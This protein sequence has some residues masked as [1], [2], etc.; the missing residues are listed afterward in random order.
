[1]RGNPIEMNH[2]FNGIAFFVAA[3]VGLALLTPV[4]N[5]VEV[6][7]SVDRNP[8]Y[9]DESVNLVLSAEGDEM[10]GASPDL[11]PLRKDFEILRQSTQTNINIVNN[12]PHVVQSWQIEI[13]PK[14]LGILEIPALTIAGE[15]TEPIELDVQEFKGNVATA[16]AEIFLE[17]VVSTNNP[18]VQAQVNFITRLYYSIPIVNGTLSEPE[19]SFATVTGP[20]Q[21]KRYNAKRAG[22]DY[23]VVERRYAMFPEQSGLFSI[24]P[25][26][27]SAV[28][29]RVDP[30]TNQIRHLSERYSSIPVELDVR[31]IPRSY[32]GTTWLPAQEL[33]LKDS[34]QGRQ[35][36][37][38]VGKPES[39]AITIDA[40]GLRAVQLP[41]VNYE[42]NSTARVYGSNNA[43]LK[44][45]PTYD[46]SVARRTDEFAIIPQSDTRV[47]V[48]RF[49]LVWWDVNEDREKIAVL[50][51]I[52]VNLDQSA[53][54]SPG[55]DSGD[56]NS[57]ADMN[58][59][60]LAL[61]GVNPDAQW[62]L[63]SLALLVTWVLTLLTWFFSRRL[64]S[65][66]N[67]Q[68]DIE[69]H[70][71]R[72]QNIETERQA[73]RSVKRACSQ[74]DALALSNALLNWAVIHWPSRP[75]RNLIELGQKLDSE[76][77]T[78]SLE[79]VDRAVYSNENVSLQGRV[80]WR[81]LVTAL[82]SIQRQQGQP[83]RFKWFK[84][85]TKRLEDLWP[86]KDPLGP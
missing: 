85:H 70:V 68:G 59:S 81:N 1:M 38:E 13:Q 79:K 50:P 39:R 63:I 74:N 29:E 15:H 49:E 12:T 46:W 44:T 52:S 37:F 11:E 41:M 8:V 67:M 84:P 33:T 23:R 42:E 83:K 36:D 78:G 19:V 26:Q 24:P 57:P 14:R 53:V 21:D 7:A 73:L 56:E 10:S 20:A 9:L 48:P 75:P 64:R 40:V 69:G 35:P 60:N 2:Q 16:G 45:T 71:L 66:K 5:A 32:S 77:L 3:V 47:E 86:Q 51:A 54:Q 43:E 82:D 25:I 28:I 76:A 55:M 4:A 65:L 80:I 30:V 34:W 27:F 31:P 72:L 17:V 6:S 61:N 62:K 58:V 18:Y 22:I